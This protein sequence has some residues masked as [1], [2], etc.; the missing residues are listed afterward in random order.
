MVHCELSSELD[1]HDTNTVGSS[2]GDGGANLLDAANFGPNRNKSTNTLD[3][4]C[5]DGADSSKCDATSSCGDIGTLVRS[6]TPLRI[7]HPIVRILL[8]IV[9]LTADFAML[10]L[11]QIAN[12]DLI[13]QFVQYLALQS[14]RNML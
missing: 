4:A 3:G 12:D 5:N 2:C 10:W 14:P 11:P 9:H 8:P 7:F 6:S 13:G 1:S